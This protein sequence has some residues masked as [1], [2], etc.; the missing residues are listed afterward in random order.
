[1]FDSARLKVERAKK[2]IGD[3]QAAFESFIQSHP[4]EFITENDPQTGI[5]TVEVRFR[6][7]VPPTLALILGDAIH[8][9]RT[10]LDHAMWELIGIDGGTPDRQTAFPFSKNRKDYEAA[11]KGIK[12]PCADTKRFF[13]TLQACPSGAGEKLYALSLLDNAEK[14]KMLTPIIGAANIGHLEIIDPNGQVYATFSNCAF[15][16]GADGRARMIATG[17]GFSGFTVR[18]DQAADLSVDMFFGKVEFFEW[19]PLAETLMELVDA[20]DN[21][22]EQLT[23]LVTARK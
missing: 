4:H 2:H 3:L 8:N 13:M 10:A 21:T 9:L 6:E 23:A 22:I 17:P 15:S 1:M 7:P 14:H 11:C 20:L 16:M 5:L 19:L 18:F 12:T